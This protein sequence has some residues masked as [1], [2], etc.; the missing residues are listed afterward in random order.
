M[1]FSLSTEAIVQS[2]LLM[3]PDK[4]EIILNQ[5]RDK[6]LN[7]LVTDPDNIQYG[8]ERKLYYKLTSLVS[9][10][11]YLLAHHEFNEF[12]PLRSTYIILSK[13]TNEDTV[14]QITIPL[15][16]D[17]L[18]EMPVYEIKLKQQLTN[19]STHTQLVKIVEYMKQIFHEISYYITPKSDFKEW[20][21]AYFGEYK[22][23]F[24]ELKK[25]VN[26]SQLS[27]FSNNNMQKVNPNTNLLKDNDNHNKTHA[28]SL[29]LS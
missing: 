20:L 8:F 16:E 19:K 21:V 24:I 10:K 13:T 29:K 1:Q 4:Q 15:N 2:F 11:K 23:G 12:I 3:T 14:N 5:Q 9:L 27:F 22:T 18:G 17:I 28:L 26:L 25:T 7:F 6:L